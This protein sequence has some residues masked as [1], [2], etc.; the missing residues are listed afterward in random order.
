MAKAMPSTWC[1][2]V[3]IVCIDVDRFCMF[4]SFDVRRIPWQKQ[5]GQ[6]KQ[7]FSILSPVVLWK[8][9]KDDR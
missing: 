8:S 1:V 2:H 5:A 7:V 4:L 9:Q 3:Y 6:T